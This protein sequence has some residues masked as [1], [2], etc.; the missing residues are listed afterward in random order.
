MSSSS[1][2]ANKMNCVT[3]R[4]LSVDV[5]TLVTTASHPGKF[6]DQWGQVKVLLTSLSCDS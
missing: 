3:L 5:V 6:L 4:S 2:F 1:P